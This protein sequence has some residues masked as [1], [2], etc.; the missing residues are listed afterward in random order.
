LDSISV[1]YIA[2]AHGVRLYFSE[3]LRRR[4]NHFS[5]F[6][7]YRTWYLNSLTLVNS[8]LVSKPYTTTVQN[9]QTFCSFPRAY[10]REHNI[11]LMYLQ[12]ILFIIIIICTPWFYTVH[13]IY[14]LAKYVV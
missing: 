13:T 3:L 6:L 10:G 1:N 9:V 8:E 14:Y 5:K 2:S 7:V 4:T 12:D 11:M